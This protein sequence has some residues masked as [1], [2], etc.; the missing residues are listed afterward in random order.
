LKKHDIQV[1]RKDT[2][3]IIE[4]EKDL[5]RKRVELARKEE[6]FN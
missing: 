3:A 2:D 5:R 6:Q 4:V 1:E